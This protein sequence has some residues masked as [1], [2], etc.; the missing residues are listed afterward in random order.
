MFETVPA[1]DRQLVGLLE[2]AGLPVD[3][4]GG[5]HQS[6]WAARGLER[7]GDD[8]ILRSVAV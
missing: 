4:L 1:P 8:V 2:A 7:C 3:D 6:F 5:A